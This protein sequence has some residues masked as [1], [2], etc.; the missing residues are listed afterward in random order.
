MGVLTGHF[1]KLDWWL[2]ISAALLVGF[3]LASI[4]SSSLP[5]GNFLNF[6]KQ[7]V[8]FVVGLALMLFL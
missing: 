6:E 2:I 3:G 1:K 7:V 5:K 4:Y 8:F